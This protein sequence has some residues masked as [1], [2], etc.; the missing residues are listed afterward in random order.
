[1]LPIML[2]RSSLSFT[3]WLP[4]VLVACSPSV[5]VPSGDTEPGS[6]SATTEVEVPGTGPG[7]TSTSG[8][9]S[10]SGADTTGTASSG[11]DFIVPGDFACV[12][13]GPGDGLSPRCSFECDVSAQDCAPG[14][15]C[16]PWA[17]DGGEFWNASR[18]SPVAREPVPPGGTCTVESSAVS[19]VD[20]CV[21]GSMCWAV[22]PRTLQGTCTE[23]CDPLRLPSTTCAAPTQC[24][25]LNDGYV[26]VCLA[27]CDP[28][29]EAACP[30]GAECRT[31]ANDGGF[32]CL[33][34]V[35]GEVEGSSEHCFSTTCAT[36]QVCVD[37]EL[38][39]DCLAF[40]CCTDLC[41]TNDPD[42]DAQCAGLDPM[43]V[44]EPFYAP[45]GAPAGLEHVGACILPM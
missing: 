28:L 26:P 6:T 5:P 22:D 4:L 21:Q 31:V 17:N 27:P 36:S 42:A 40:G 44:C 20:D 43:L 2:A 16:M 1:M 11:I 29:E 38:L 23:F 39:S 19:G 24:V 34:L 10:T 25:S 13:E 45:G 9:S 12:H 35:G 15:K 37:A 41:D 30:A 32:Y 8:A 3:R 14:D 18:C 7:M 33:P